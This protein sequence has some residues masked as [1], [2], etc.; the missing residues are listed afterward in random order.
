MAKIMSRTKLLATLEAEGINPRSITYEA[1]GKVA[2]AFLR[3]ASIPERQ[4]CEFF[5]VNKCAYSAKQVV[6]D[7]FPGSACAQVQVSY[8]KA[9]HWDE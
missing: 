1:F 9:W 6:L 5:L 7:Y 8:F 2:Y 3:F 4:A